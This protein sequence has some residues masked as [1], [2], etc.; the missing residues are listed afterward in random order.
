MNTATYVMRY[1]L[2]PSF[3]VLF[4]LKG[5]QNIPVCINRILTWNKTSPVQNNYYTSHVANYC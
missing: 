1:F 5:E 3:S 2:F 4:L